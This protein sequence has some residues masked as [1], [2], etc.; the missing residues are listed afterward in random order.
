MLFCFQKWFSLYLTPKNYVVELNQQ[1]NENFNQPFFNNYWYWTYIVYNLVFSFNFS[2]FFF[3]PIFQVVSNNLWCNSAIFSLLINFD[4]LCY[5]INQLKFWYHG[6][7]LIQANTLKGT[8]AALTITMCL[9]NDYILGL[10]STH[11]SLFCFV[12]NSS[13]YRYN[14]L[15]F[16]CFRSIFNIL[17][18]FLQIL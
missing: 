18:Q 12:E 14:L 3:Q 8:M 13:Y 17:Y 4:G 6:L 16:S 1:F 2:A 5:S 7:G 15:K 9:F 10:T 11:I